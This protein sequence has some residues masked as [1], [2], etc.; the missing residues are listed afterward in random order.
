M[1]LF[2]KFKKNLWRGFKATLHFRKSITYNKLNEIIYGHIVLLIKWHF[3]MPNASFDLNYRE[4]GWN[5][6]VTIAAVNAIFTQMQILVWKIF[7]RL[8]QDSNL[9][10]LHSRCSAITNWAMKTHMLRADQFIEFF[11]TCDRNKTWNEVNLN[12]STN[13]EVVGSNP[14]EALKIVFGLK[15]AIA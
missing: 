7:S 14:V 8:Q 13:A 11:F 10:P 9:W 15:F 1:Q 4:N 6:D 2:A 5:W 3:L 12:C